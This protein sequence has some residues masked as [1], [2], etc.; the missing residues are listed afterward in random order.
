MA[1]VA[2]MGTL[3]LARRGLRLE[4]LLELLERR[5][6][7]GEIAR[8]QRLTNIGQVLRERVVGVGGGERG[9]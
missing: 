1:V 9:V 8:L 5:L 3:N 6:G 2:A 7:P 4:V